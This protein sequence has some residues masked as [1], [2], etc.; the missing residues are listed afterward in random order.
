MLCK[1][2]Y[3]NVKTHQ[4][5]VG[6]QEIITTTPQNSTVSLYI[7]HLQTLSSPC[8]PLSSPISPL[9]PQ[10]HTSLSL[11]LSLCQFSLCKTNQSIHPLLFDSTSIPSNPSSIKP[12]LFKLLGFKYRLVSLS[13]FLFNFSL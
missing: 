2:T 6:V 5:Y 11:S 9:L 13:F 3:E 7:G 1:E 4:V 12:S 8:R 10:S